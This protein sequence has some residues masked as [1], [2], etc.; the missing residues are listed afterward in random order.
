MPLRTLL[1]LGL[2]VAAFLGSIFAHPIIGVYAYL[3]TY[4]I[5]PLGQWWGAY[6]PGFAQRYAML[7][8][9]A[10]GLGVLFQ[11]SKLRYGRL[12]VR[13]EVL[14]ILFVGIM[15]LSVVLGQGSGIHFNI[16]K[17]TKVLF[18]LLMASHIITTRRFF[19]G[20]VWVFIIS[21]L[22]LGYE[23][24]G[25]AGTTRG[26][27]FDAGVGGSDFGEGNFLA[28]HFAFILPFI[29]VVLAKGS[30]KV[31]LFTLVPAVFIVNAIVIT[32]SRGA[33]LALAVAGIAA[34]LL[35]ARVKRYR[36]QLVLLLFVGALGAVT[37]T[38]D[39]FWERMVTI[40]AQ[41]DFGER[42][43]SAQHRLDAWHGAWL[44]AQDHP[45]GVGVGNFFHQIGNYYPELTGRDTHNTYLRC[46]AEL[47]FHGFFV[48]V[49]L[50]VSAFFMLWRI[51]R[52][53]ESLD[54][55]PQNFFHLYAF[56]L[57]LSLI[58]YLVA[59]MFIS[60]VYIEEFYCCF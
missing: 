42:D 10:I 41:E 43:L 28:A 51:E 1:Y 20:M 5:N 56:A 14:L 33:F 53:C 29:G 19:E 6:L 58:A 50:I 23:M 40:Q 9:L 38:D 2:F 37:L 59:A 25:G 7:L 39:M 32:R 12:L 24:Y 18:V 48:L 45:L 22:Y 52:E 16:E 54:H 8:A 27:R 4:N 30:W 31:R 13:Q 26:G 3:A 17:M 35:S 57:K 46:L 15:W 60:S 21:G 34:L 36:K 44:M 47:G 49:M 55:E 11:H